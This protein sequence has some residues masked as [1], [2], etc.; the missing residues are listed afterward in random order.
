MKSDVPVRYSIKN[1]DKEVNATYRVVLAA[2]MQHM[3]NNPNTLDLSMDTLWC[4][5][6]IERVGDHVTNICEYIV[7]L[8]KGKDVRHITREDMLKDITE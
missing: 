2:L 4:L 1:T 7:F 3:S 8:V 5:R 6:S